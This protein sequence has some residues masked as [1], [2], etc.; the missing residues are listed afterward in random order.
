MEID[1]VVELDFGLGL[2]VKITVEMRSQTFFFFSNL[3]LHFIILNFIL[4]NNLLHTM[5]FLNTYINN[6]LK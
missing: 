6:V 5:I 2:K 1:G 4:Y 3:L